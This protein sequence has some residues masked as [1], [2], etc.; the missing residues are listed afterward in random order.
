[1]MNTQEA[2]QAL[3]ARY[4]HLREAFVLLHPRLKDEAHWVTLVLVLADLQVQLDTKRQTALGLMREQFAVPEPYHALRHVPDV[5][6]QDLCCI[7]EI[8][9]KTNADP[10][11]L[12]KMREKHRG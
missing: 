1:M 4:P 2:L 6:L 12:D 3:F 10:E 9:H 8:Q 7:A 5:I 11:W